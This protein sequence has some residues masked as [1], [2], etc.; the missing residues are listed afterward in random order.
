MSLL[1]TTYSRWNFLNLIYRQQQTRLID[2]CVLYNNLRCLSGDSEPLSA[3]PG[4]WFFQQRGA[5]WHQVHRKLRPG[6]KLQDYCV[7]KKQI[8]ILLKLLTWEEKIKAHHYSLI[9]QKLTWQKTIFPQKYI[10]NVL[11][12]LYFAAVYQLNVYYYLKFI[13]IYNIAAVMLVEC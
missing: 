13:C 7:S 10:L 6:T 1:E 3:G 4:V 5:V 11:M 2:E 12:L 9:Y 8:S